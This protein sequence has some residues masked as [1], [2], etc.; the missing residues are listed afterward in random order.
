[1][2]WTPGT[3]LSSGLLFLFSRRSSV[4]SRL[5]LD[6]FQLVDRTCAWNTVFL[7]RAVILAPVDATQFLGPLL[8]ASLPDYL[9]LA[10]FFESLSAIED[11]LLAR[12]MGLQRYFDFKSFLVWP[13]VSLRSSLS[14]FPLSRD[15]L[16]AHLFSYPFSIWT[17]P[18]ASP[19]LL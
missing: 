14:H 5:L 3:S 11:P 2:R 7:L 1:M 16:G 8:P 4:I 6:F 12:S 19:P 15:M 13:P 18:P 17:L 9:S 10:S